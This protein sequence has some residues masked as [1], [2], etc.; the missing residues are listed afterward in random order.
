MELPGDVVELRHQETGDSRIRQERFDLAKHPNE[1]NRFGWIVEIDPHDPTS[2]PVKHTAMGRFKHEGANVIINADGRVVAYMGD[3]ER[4]DY[5]YRFVSRDTM[6]PG[7]SPKARRHNLTLLSEGDLSVA[8]FSGDGLEDGVSDGTGEWLPLTVDGESVEPASGEIRD[9]KTPHWTGTRNSPATFGHFGGS[10]TFLWVDPALDRSL[11]CLTDREYGPWALETW[12]P[13]SD[14]V[15]AA[16][17]A[18]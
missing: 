17:A 18:S 13:F 2:T 4:F 1:A 15:L 12:P 14:V 16:L 11:V 9:G 7:N 6:R 10:G 8:R 3:D 5:V